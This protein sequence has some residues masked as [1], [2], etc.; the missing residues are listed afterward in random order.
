MVD[1]V[2]VEVLAV[3]AVGAAGVAIGLFGAARACVGAVR[4]ARARRR[5]A[6]V[7]GR[8]A[9]A[10][11][12]DGAAF[13]DAGGGA[14]GVTLPSTASSPEGYAWEGG[15]RGARPHEVV[16][17]R[18]EARQWTSLS[19][20]F[21]GFPMRLSVRPSRGEAR[22]ALGR[23]F[24]FAFQ[25]GDAQFDDVF[26][27]ETETPDEA[28]AVLGV[29]MRRALLRLPRSAE[30]PRLTVDGTTLRVEWHGEPDPPLVQRVAAA[31]HSARR[32]RPS[33]HG[34]QA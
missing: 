9:N 16:P 5:N 8:A 15:Y 4:R 13:D 29:E 18:A 11:G 25:T 6:G 10:L 17:V 3:H 31:L 28:A 12:L 7:L 26:V 34:S 2:L 1:S 32:A 24:G 20:A 19:A 27:V 21:A 33:I 14:V 23:R 22:T 30:S